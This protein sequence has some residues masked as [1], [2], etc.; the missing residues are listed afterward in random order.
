MKTWK[1]YLDDVRPR[2]EGYVL[3]RS[4]AEA[5][6]LVTKLGCPNYIS[7]DHDL[8]F[9]EDGTEKNGYDFAK[10]LIEMDLDGKLSF[11]E[12][13]GFNAHSSNPKG[14]ENIKMIITN[15]LEFKSKQK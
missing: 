4:F 7:F 2:P 15:Y 11:P 5:V 13:F 12:D 10:W 3:A 8:G 9:L 6:D 14:R 1:L